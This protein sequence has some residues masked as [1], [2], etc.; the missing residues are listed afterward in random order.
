MTLLRKSYY[1]LILTFFSICALAIAQPP[2]VYSID[3]KKG[4][5]DPSKLKAPID[6]KALGVT[7]ER[8]PCSA[9][10]LTGV[11]TEIQNSRS[12][13]FEH[14]GTLRNNMS[15]L[16][17]YLDRR[18]CQGPGENPNG[19]E[20]LERFRQSTLRFHSKINRHTVF[21]PDF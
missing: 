2:L 3:F 13:V 15:D 9:M 14:L 18:H 1:T 5:P 16:R 4:M 21:H 17:S 12:Q 8:P 6:K 7:I 20:C 11:V 10:E 19:N